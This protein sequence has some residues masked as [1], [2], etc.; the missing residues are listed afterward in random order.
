M[1][2]SINLSLK[3]KVEAQSKESL[4]SEMK[5]NTPTW[6]QPAQHHT[7]PTT[8]GDPRAPV[9]FLKAQYFISKC[10]VGLQEKEAYTSVLVQYIPPQK[11]GHKDLTILLKDEHSLLSLCYYEQARRIN[12]RCCISP[13]AL[14]EPPVLGKFAGE[15]S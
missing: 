5:A 3:L 8:L 9:S 10:L 11:A 13:V 12:A 1:Q 7:A 15:E 4:S 14:E 2:P 6:L